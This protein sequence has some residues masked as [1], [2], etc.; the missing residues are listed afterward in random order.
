MEKLGQP[1]TP[2]IAALVLV[3]TR[4]LAM[5]VV[6]QYNALRAKQSQ[7]AGLVV[8]GLP[9]GRQLDAIRKGARL[10]VATPCRLEDYLDRR[11]VSLI[12]VMTLVLHA[13]DRT[14]DT[15][16]LPPTIRNHA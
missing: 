7:P 9:E 4:E 8:G 14:S 6:A 5:Q 3:P 13:A 10:V 16:I 2:G 12:G 1:H 15:A 11:L